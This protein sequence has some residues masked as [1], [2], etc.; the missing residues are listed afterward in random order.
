MLAQALA[1]LG[2]PADRVRTSTVTGAGGEGTLAVTEL[3]PP[4]TDM[5]EDAKPLV[6]LMH[7]I[8]D[9]S[10]TFR[11][12]APKIADAGYTVVAHDLRGSGQTSTTFASYLPEEAAKDALAVAE[13]AVASTAEAVAT[14]APAS[15]PDARAALNRK[16][17]VLVGHSYSAASAVW[18]A[19]EAPEAVRGLVFL[20]PFVRDPNEGRGLSAGMKLMLRLLMSR[21][22]GAGF[23]ASYYSGTLHKHPELDRAELQRH[24]AEIRR[25]LDGPHLAALRA[26]MFATKAACTARLPQVRAPSLTII[27]GADPDYPSPAAEAAYITG[28]LAHTGRAEQLLVDGVGHYPHFEQTQATADAIL[29]FLGSLAVP[30]EAPAATA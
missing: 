8:G 17:V 2:V 20:G 14:D 5:A 25:M 22:I 19:A 16:G 9:T 4:A 18:A 21:P 10:A 23:W 12:I 1:R 28:A 11:H 26:T 13:A 15:T 3:A 30:T 27:G 29:R 6:L 7:G 24:T